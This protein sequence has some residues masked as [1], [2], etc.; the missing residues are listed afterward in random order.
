MPL[1]PLDSSGNQS[2][3]QENPGLELFVKT[4]CCFQNLHVTPGIPI[5]PVPDVDSGRAINES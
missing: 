1:P 3:T 2:C 5:V 4:L